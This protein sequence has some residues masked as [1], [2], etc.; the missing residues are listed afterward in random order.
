MPMKLDG[1][2]SRNDGRFSALQHCIV[3]G[4]LWRAFAG[5]KAGCPSYANM[6]PHWEEA[7]VRWVLFK[8]GQAIAFFGLAP[9]ATKGDGPSYRLF[10]PLCWK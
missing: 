3:V 4:A 7:S 2:L 1:P 8:V 10:S 5:T 9:W 6:R